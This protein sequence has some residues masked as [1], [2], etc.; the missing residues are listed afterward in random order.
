[1]KWLRLLPAVLLGAVLLR[2]KPWAQA[3]PAVSWVSIAT[4]V[5]LNFAIFLP[6]RVWRWRI[7]LASPPRF[8]SLY[9][10]LLEGL[11]ANAAIGFGSGDVVRAARLRGKATFTADYGATIAE[12][13]AELIAIACLLLFGVSVANLGWAG[14]AGACA[15]LAVYAVGLGFGHR[16]LPRLKRW[17]RLAAGLSAGI[18]ASTPGRVVGMTALSLLGWLSEI[19]ILMV[20]LA[21]FDLPHSA[22]TA[23]LVLLGINV[24]IV[25][26][27]P[28]ANFGTFEAGVIAALRA[29]NVPLDSA[30]VFA[31]GYH[32][33]MSIPPALAGAI[34]FL[35]RGRRV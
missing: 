22:G 26:P 31:I 9:A 10:S 8:F 16:L 12:R 18:A 19:A 1:M 20:G 32:L 15:C 25:V 34:L 28:P 35:T 23:L 2:E 29:S 21:A 13:G 3:W 4:M 27:G 14:V 33:I 24:A 6:T 17:P 11:L 5:A 7:A 30:L